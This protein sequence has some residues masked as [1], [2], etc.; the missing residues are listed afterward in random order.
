MSID[1][2]PVTCEV[3]YAKYIHPCEISNCHIMSSTEVPFSSDDSFTSDV[4]SYSNIQN[5]NE[6]KPMG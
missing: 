3:K 1:I 2:D 6:Q 5:S 4:G